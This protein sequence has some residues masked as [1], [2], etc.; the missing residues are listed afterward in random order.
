MDTVEIS[1]WKLKT[2]HL[3]AKP[4][5]LQTKHGKHD[6]KPQSN[7]GVH[8]RTEMEMPK[9]E[10]SRPP[11]WT[12]SPPKIRSEIYESPYKRSRST[13]LKKYLWHQFSPFFTSPAEN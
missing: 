11:T 7:I 8:M 6:E 12:A 5:T 9:F 2:S 4:C 1:F 13:L 3:R 10:K